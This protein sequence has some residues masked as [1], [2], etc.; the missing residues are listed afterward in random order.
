MEMKA[1]LYKFTAYDVRT[2]LVHDFL[3]IKFGTAKKLAVPLIIF[4]S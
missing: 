3:C 1:V 2:V 4:P